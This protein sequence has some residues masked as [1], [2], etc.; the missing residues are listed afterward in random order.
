[1]EF[2]VVM[3]KNEKSNL[4]ELIGRDVQEILNKKEKE[5]QHLL[6]AMFCVRKKGK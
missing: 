5:N 6:Y 1:M 4:W 3:K 2:Y